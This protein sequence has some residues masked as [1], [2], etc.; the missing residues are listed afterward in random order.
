M[1]YGGKALFTATSPSTGNPAQPITTRPEVDVHPSLDGYLVYFGTG[2]YIETNDNQNIGQNT[3]TIYAVG[4][5]T[6]P[7]SALCCPKPACIC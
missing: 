3:Q 6:I 2:K 7:T 5:G 1:A 4:I